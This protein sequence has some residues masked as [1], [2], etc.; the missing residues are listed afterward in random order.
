M[1]CF[2]KVRVKDEKGVTSA[3]SRPARWTVGP[4]ENSDWSGRWIGADDL[5]TRGRGSPPPDNRVPDPWLRK[6][7][8]LKAKPERAS[9]CVASV[10]YHELYVNGHRIGDAVLSPSATNHRKRARYVTYE[11][12]DQLQEG[13][14]VIALWLGRLVV[15]LPAVQDPG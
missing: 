10:G 11:I 14:N 3:W 12:A 1:E 7:F 9:I 15:D 4:L 5:F 8:A 13:K 6:A 2:W